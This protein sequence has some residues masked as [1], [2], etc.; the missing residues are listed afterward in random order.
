M[1]DA[2]TDSM[3]VD[4]TDFSV[5]SSVKYTKPKVNP[6][7]GK[8]IGILNSQMNKGLYIS[9]PLMLTWGVNEY[10]D[11]KSGRKTYDMSL[12]FPK[13]E[14][15]TEPVEKFLKSMREFESKIKTDAIENSKE[16]MNK[17]KMSSEVIDALWT[18]MLK[19]P[20]D[21]ETGE[22]DYTRAPTLRLKIPV[23][24]GEWK[25]ELYDVDRKPL[26]PNEQGLLPTDLISKG[27]N[28]A[29][30]ML[31]GGIWFAN[32]KFGVTWKLVQAVVKPKAT[33]RGQCFISLDAKDKE[34]MSN[35]E[36]DDG[37]GDTAGVAVVDSSSD[38]DEELPTVSEVKQEVKQ[39]L[40]PSPAT[41]APK[42][43]VIRRKKVG[44]E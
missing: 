44:A 27:S 17:T 9:T 26:F 35:V 29:T 30:V 4:G 34:I 21:Q 36:D 32:G 11:D 42:K 31:C 12:Q 1:G 25:V 10:T 19:Y 7:G 16:W 5:N 20:K 23:W 2:K 14:Y 18:P 39:E 8:S 33:M 24:D 13:E 3:I 43:K 28:I 40:T 38:D 6:S 37:D 22:F 15:K 41:D